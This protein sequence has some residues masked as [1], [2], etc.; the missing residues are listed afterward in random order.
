[1]SITDHME[2]VIIIMKK[3]KKFITKCWIIRGHDNFFL[4]LGLNVKS[5]Q[6][7]WKQIKIYVF[8]VRY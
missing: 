1:M 2:S 8:L 6:E 7:V 3:G 5:V 4:I